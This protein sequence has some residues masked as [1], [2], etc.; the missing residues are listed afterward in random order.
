M[1]C[2]TQS[3]MREGDTN[4]PDILLPRVCRSTKK[5]WRKVSIDIGDRHPNLGNRG[6]VDSST[7]LSAYGLT[8][9]YGDSGRKASVSNFNCHLPHEMDKDYAMIKSQI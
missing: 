6:K 5:N 2:Q 4:H 9:V 3:S 1:A 8:G 7:V